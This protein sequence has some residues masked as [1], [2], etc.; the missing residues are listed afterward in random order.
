[1]RCDNDENRGSTEASC[2][3]AGHSSA[4]SE[5]KAIVKKKKSPN[6]MSLKQNFAK[7]KSSAKRL[8]LKSKHNDMK[9]PLPRHH[10]LLGFEAPRRAA[11]DL[12]Q[13]SNHW[14][15]IVKQY[16]VLELSRETDRLPALSGLAMRASA[17]L[18]QYL[19]GM[20][21][22]TLSRDILWRVPLL[23]DEH[24]RP[25][26]FTAPSWSW[27]SVKGVVDYWQDLDGEDDSLAQAGGLASFE[28]E[29]EDA[30]PWPRQEPPPYQADWGLPS[31]Y[32][33][34]VDHTGQNPFGAVTSGLL[35]IT[36]R[37][38]PATLVYGH[39]VTNRGT[40]RANTYDPFVYRVDIKGVGTDG[41]RTDL[42]L[43]FFA[44]YI[45]SRGMSRVSQGEG[46]FIFL[47]AQ[48]ICLVLR[49]VTTNMYERIGIVRQSRD[50]VSLYA[51][52]W[53]SGGFRGTIAIV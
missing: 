39:H 32:D 52:D 22:E 7:T 6:W 1:M 46:V 21:K 23:D 42:E 8:V 15:S 38:A 19:C 27:A 41:G 49:K 51:I 17:V 25:T 40:K 48:N 18:G 20:W 53:M 13:N 24:G 33:C 37:I 14:H 47:V 5:Q 31:H 36:G 35:Q 28:R 12:M 10:E 34:I 29:A 43:P 4:P 16:S 26:R 11:S 2:G 50:Y 30:L 44:D 3:S 45:L 9:A